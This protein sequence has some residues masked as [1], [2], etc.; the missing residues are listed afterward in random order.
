M[1]HAEPFRFV[2][3]PV[4]SR[5]LGLSLGVDLVPFKTCTYDCVYC[6]LGPTT[7]RTATRQTFVPVEAVLDEVGRRLA[8][9]S[10]PDVITLS[11][12]GEPTL[13]A[14]IGAVIEGIKRMTAIPVAVLTNGSLL[15]DEAV[16]C[17]LLAADIVVPSLDAGS[18]G[19][20]ARINRPH[21]SIDFE[22]MVEG[23]VAFRREYA[24][25]LWLEIFLVADLND[26]DEEIDRM[27]AIVER[28][29]PDRVQLNTIARPPAVAGMHT[30]PPDRLSSIAAC[31]T[32][33]AEVVAEFAAPIDAKERGTLDDIL[34]MIRRRPC[35]TDD[36]AQA[37]GLHRNEVLKFLEHLARDEAIDQRR[38]ERKIYWIPHRT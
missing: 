31:F 37:F 29:H 1:P 9:E 26:A 10:A 3:G 32:P 33:S 24:G 18:P 15:W 20:F 28:I 4:P 25:Q 21:E 22:T 17:S 16:R 23:L 11:G 34:A 13:H 36:V 38:S 7:D 27:V 5:R 35:T 14:E 12:S 8:E 30:L 19:V 2:F 6:Q